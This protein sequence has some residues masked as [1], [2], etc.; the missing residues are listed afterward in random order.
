PSF[1]AVDLVPDR[2]KAYQVRRREERAAN[3]TINY[4]VAVLRRG[5]QLAVESGQLTVRHKFAML[6]VGNNARKGFFERDQLETVVEHLPDHL[7]P[8]MLTAYLTGWR[9]KSELLTRCWKHV[10]FETGKLILDPDEGKTRQARSFPLIDEL[11][12]LLLAQR[13]RVSE[14]ERSIGQ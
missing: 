7:R 11:R 6:D 8:V 13:E 1:R 14:L 5:L 2:L 12:E 10:N 4:E 3:S 9:T